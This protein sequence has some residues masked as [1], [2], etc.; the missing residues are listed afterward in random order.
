MHPS[1]SLEP[2]QRLRRRREPAGRRIRLLLLPRRPRP[3]GVQDVDLVQGQVQV[4]VGG[5]RVE[6]PGREWE[7]GGE[8][9]SVFSLLEKKECS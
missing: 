6:G 3:L 8:E 9:S 7:C 5:L 2:E 1:P 4:G